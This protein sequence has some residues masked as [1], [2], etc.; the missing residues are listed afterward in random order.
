MAY[1]FRSLAA[2]IMAAFFLSSGSASAQIGSTAPSAKDAQSTTA[3]GAPRS[4]KPGWLGVHISNIGAEAALE[5]GLGEGSAVQVRYPAPYSPAELAGL[6]RRDVVLSIEGTP[7]HSTEAFIKAVATRGVGAKVTLEVLRRGER[8][9][10]TAVLGSKPVEPSP[11][12]PIIRDVYAFVSETTSRATARTDLR[13]LDPDTDLISHYEPLPFLA[14]F[15]DARHEQIL[16]RF[17]NGQTNATEV[18]KSLEAIQS[19]RSLNLSVAQI[20]RLQ[21]NIASIALTSERNRAN[22]ETI[23]INSRGQLSIWQSDSSK[24]WVSERTAKALQDHLAPIRDALNCDR[25]PRHGSHDCAELFYI[26]SYATPHRDENRRQNLLRRAIE[27]HDPTISPD[28]GLLLYRSHIKSL[29]QMKQ[30]PSTGPSLAALDPAA[31]S[32]LQDTLTAHRDAALGYLRYARELGDFDAEIHAEA[33]A[34]STISLF[35]V[36]YDTVRS[37]VRNVLARVEPVIEWRIRMGLGTLGGWH[38]ARTH[39]LEA[40]LRG[41]GANVD[42]FKRIVSWDFEVHLNQDAPF[43]LPNGTLSPEFLYLHGPDQLLYGKMLDWERWLRQ[44]QRMEQVFEPLA[45]IQCERDDSAACALLLAAEFVDLNGNHPNPAQAFLA[46]AIEILEKLNRTRS[47]IYCRVLIGLGR[48]QVEHGELNAAEIT[49]AKASAVGF[50]LPGSQQCGGVFELWELKL[51]LARKRIDQVSIEAAMQ[52]LVAIAYS[53]EPATVSSRD[54]AMLRE[55]VTSELVQHLLHWD[56]DGCNAGFREVARERLRKSLSDFKIVSKLA[57]TR[58]F[59]V[60]LEALLRRGVLG[61][62]VCAE[63]LALLHETSPLAK[64]L[65]SPDSNAICDPRPW[66]ESERERVR[67][68]L[69]NGVVA[70]TATTNSAL[71]TNESFFTLYAAAA[72][73][74][75]EQRQ[76]FFNAW[77]QG[78]VEPDRMTLWFADPREHFAAF[79]LAA[80]AAR[81]VGGEDYETLWLQLTEEF[82][83]HYTQ[84]TRRSTAVEILKSHSN[85]GVRARQMLPM[86]VSVNTRLADIA[87]TRGDTSGALSHASRA[88]ALAE[89]RLQREWTEENVDAIGS[90]RPAAEPLRRLASV[91]SR[92]VAEQGQGNSEIHEMAFK[93]M[94]YAQ[95]T[96]TSLAV[97]GTLRRKRDAHPDMVD[98]IKR[99]AEAKDA[100]WGSEARRAKLPILEAAA[101]DAESD[102]LYEVFATSER[103]VTQRRA[104]E[105]SFLSIE[106]SSL[107]EV[108]SSLRET[109]ALLL[110]L[111]GPELTQFALVTRTSS[112]FWSAPIGRSKL[113]REIAALRAPFD[114]PRQEVT[115]SAEAAFELYRSLLLPLD[116]LPRLGVDKIFYVPDGP[117][118]SMPLGILVTRSPETDAV[119]GER[120]LAWLLRDYAV[121]VLPSAVSFGALRKADRRPPGDHAFAGIGDPILTNHTELAQLVSVR[122]LRGTEGKIDP[123]KVRA[124]PALPET[125]SELQQIAS[126]LQAGP[127]NRKTKLWLGL[128]ATRGKIRAADLSRYEIISF[129]THGL[130]AGDIDGLHEPG[131]VLTPLDD[132]IEEHGFLSATDISQLKL[133]ASLVI[134]SACNTAAS[135]GRPKAEGLSGLA[136]SFFSAGARTIL[137]TSWSIPSGPTVDLMIATIGQRLAHP[138]LDWA[139]VVRRAT[140][141]AIDRNPKSPMADP[142]AWGAFLVIG[143][144]E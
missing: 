48:Y 114:R 73:D 85:V 58:P 16:S 15:V 126:L 65:Q 115:F 29:P 113:E 52:R 130:V 61:V 72:G 8:T 82:Y 54:A 132:A 47:S 84:L 41:G 96:D 70:V 30:V 69:I 14:E 100:Y 49:L 46:D 93:A 19:D 99:A 31:S 134:L 80:K 55:Q 81:E 57:S 44:M 74:I 133:G 105:D 141:D 53:S 51:E 83:D 97:I 60:A 78:V 128:D 127:R 32:A 144:G 79:Q 137:A 125:R 122:S 112:R 109:E 17:V 103:A 11:G 43:S 95:L 56:C 104:S 12:V 138:E 62:A 59:A 71:N 86:I 92:M 38:R 136:R 107:V 142:Y 88:F 24:S 118:H 94:Q 25:A 76:H 20:A 117:L 106:P 111:S 75:V 27:A 131:L 68:A 66:S 26:D 13:L 139:Q 91:L 42:L 18:V 23:D 90:L 110:S 39:V 135:D 40:L 45:A 33:I 64:S 121:S 116:D 98:L 140:I 123:A 124:L 22:Q 28:L 36:P 34:A 87:L 4:A 108:R 63:A 10:L 7:V 37:M 89:A 119:Q 1:T 2:T 9:R 67:H 102:R 3:A 77:A 129:A 101:H 35:D 6:R 50:E 21:L 143:V 5:L 120:K